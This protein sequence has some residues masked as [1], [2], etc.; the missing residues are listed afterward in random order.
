RQYPAINQTPPSSMTPASWTAAYE[1]AKARGAIP[2]YPVAAPGGTGQYPQGT[3]VGQVCSWT[4]TKC[5]GH[6]DIYEAPANEWAVS[7]D[8]GPTQQSEGLYRFLASQNQTST[9][10]MI[11]SQVLDFPNAL[12]VAKQSNIQM[13]LHT[14]SHT[15][16]CGLT[17]EQIVAELG[18][19]M[20]IVMDE[21]GLLPALYRPPQGDV[22]DRVRAIAR[23][24]FG[25]RAV[26]WAYDSNDWCL[27][28]QGGSACPGQVPGQDKQ[29]VVD[30]IYQTIYKKDRSQ[31]VI[32]LEHELT[33]D[34]VGIFESYYPTL[35]TAGWQPHCIA[36]L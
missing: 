15:P 17:D 26:M 19:N 8:D 1:A 36:E 14:W 29:S 30:Y 5:F 21:T 6:D 4:A 3:N 23:E 11:G 28:G 7:F 31:G 24:V 22:D 34:S 13:A 9:S 16:L 2:G 33:T 12:Q 25:L 35:K 18:W 10:F 20:Q 27:N 32:I